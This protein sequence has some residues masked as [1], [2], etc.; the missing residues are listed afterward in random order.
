MA[1]SGLIAGT[2]GL[3]WSLNSE[4]NSIWSYTEIM[5]AA[6]PALAL[7]ADKA[8]IPINIETGGANNVVVQWTAIAGS[9]TS[10]R[11]NVQIALDSAFTQVV[12][13]QGA[14]NAVLAIIGPTAIAPFTFAFQADTTYYLRVRI[15]TPVDSP[16]SASRSFK[17]DALRPLALQSPASGAGAVPV[18]PTFVWSPVAGATTYELV[19][20]DDPTFAIITFSRTTSQPVF[21]SDEQ[22]AYGTVYYWR[23][24]ASAPATAVTPFVPGI[25]TTMAKPVAPTTAPPP[26][27]VTQTSVTV[28]IPPATTV[29]VIPSYLLIII[30]GIGVILVIALFVL[31]MRTRARG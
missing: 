24:R 5:A 21:A 27:T 8:V 31:I 3:L 15:D 20:S 19:V 14:I 4:D 25:F 12:V 18:N 17:V 2:G 10:T 22:L 29:E 13:D 9:P 11:Y 1:P 23:V 16:W 26:V 6:G 28:T 30:I 7:P